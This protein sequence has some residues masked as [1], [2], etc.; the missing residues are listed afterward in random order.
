M[1]LNVSPSTHWIITESFLKALTSIVS[2]GAIVIDFRATFL[3]VADGTM[4][5]DRSW[6]LDD[7]A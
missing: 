2:A 1:I 3:H 4:I 5:D 7:L 6:I